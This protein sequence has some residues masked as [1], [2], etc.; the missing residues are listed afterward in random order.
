M[1]RL[2]DDT[3]RKPP[4][5]GLEAEVF[6]NLLRT[7][8]LLLRVETEV[9]K[10][11]DLTS[12]QYNVLRILRAAGEPGVNCAQIAERMVTRDPDVTRLLDR[13]ERRGLVSRSREQT[14][15]RV[16]T[17]RISKE[18]K[19]LVDALDKPVEAR[20][21][22]LLGHMGRDKLRT[23]VSLLAEARGETETTATT[24]APSASPT[25]PA[26]RRPAAKRRRGL[27]PTAR[28]IARELGRAPLDG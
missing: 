27:P 12:A 7:A 5:S 28:E 24:P 13:L 2:K 10:T 21:R 22:E 15:R 20:N 11:G 9:L 1:A 19:A 23:L 6:L 3:Q 14:D 17:I 18:G 4:V 16:I 26:L 8:D 25:P